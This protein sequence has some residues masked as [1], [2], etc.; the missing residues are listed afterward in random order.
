MNR[1]ADKIIMSN[2]TNLANES[3][4]LKVNHLGS[5][6][7]K[8]LMAGHALSGEFGFL[9]ERLHTLQQATEEVKS[10]MADALPIEILQNLWVVNLSKEQ[11]T[12]TVTSTTAAN[13][14][15]YLKQSFI[16]IL[17]E[18]STSFKQ[19]NELKVIVCQLPNHSQ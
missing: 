1:Q 2:Q 10:I 5:R 14:I 7:E 16:K 13:H 15:H 12:L 8:Q 9:E 4:H 18:Q 17:Q 3:K 11:I 19:L 6:V